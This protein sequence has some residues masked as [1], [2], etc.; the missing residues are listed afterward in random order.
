MSH[1]NTNAKYRANFAPR[2]KEQT[3][4]EGIFHSHKQDK[5]YEIHQ[6]NPS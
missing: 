5:Q 3:F 2:N 6:L 4:Y 1:G